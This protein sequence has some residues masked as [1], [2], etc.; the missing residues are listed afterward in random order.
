[1]MSIKLWQLLTIIDNKDYINLR[2]CKLYE[3]G[4]TKCMFEY[5]DLHKEDIT[6]NLKMLLYHD[7]KF[8]YWYDN[9]LVLEIYHE[10]N[11]YV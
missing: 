9:Y 8:M 5:D 11:Y 10:D 2:V 4:T 7:I 1:M 3:N 6:N